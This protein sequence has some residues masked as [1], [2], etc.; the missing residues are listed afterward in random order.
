LAVTPE[1]Q[2]AAA[3][4]IGGIPFIPPG[5]SSSVTSPGISAFAQ[6][7]ATYVNNSNAALLLRSLGLGDVN[8]DCIF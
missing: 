5:A 8:P 2:R 6:Q 7:A 1:Q 4:W 3:Y